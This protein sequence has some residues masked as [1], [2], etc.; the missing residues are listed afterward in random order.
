MIVEYAFFQDVI[1]PDKIS[2]SGF[3]RHQKNKIALGPDQLYVKILWVR[4]NVDLIVIS[5]DSLYF[6]TEVAHSIYQYAYSEFNITKDHIILNASHTHSAPNMDLEFFGNIDRKYLEDVEAKIKRGLRLCHENFQKGYIE[7]R[8]VECN[9]NVFISRRKIGR[10]I[11]TFFIKKRIIMQPNEEKPVDRNI[12]LI[13]LYDSNL[14]LDGI[15]YNFSC[16]PV[17]NTTYNI[18]SDFIG[19]ISSILEER[20]CKFSMFLQG[21]AGDVRPNYTETK[22]SV[23]HVINFAKLLFNEKVFCNFTQSHFNDFCHHISSSIIEAESENKDIRPKLNDSWC[24]IRNFMYEDFIESKTAETRKSLT[25]KLVLLSANLFI[26]IPAEVHSSYLGILREA[27]PGL[28]IYP[29]GYADGMIGYLPCEEEIREGGY[30]VQ[31]SVKYYGWDDSMSEVSVRN[32]TTR[33]IKEMKNLLKD[34]SV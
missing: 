14:K 13:K 6:S 20:I 17:F 23:K 2:L 19:Y 11:R 29:L 10:D 24:H 22:T 25:I 8:N 12:R 34:Q 26:S 1:N 32:F 30:E 9:A 15:I 28:K 3:S 33:L 18:S 21:F 16:H 27:F 7:F 4:A 31:K 5:I